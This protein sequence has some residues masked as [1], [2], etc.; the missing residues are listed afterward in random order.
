MSETGK[1]RDIFIL[2]VWRR[3]RKVL[4]LIVSDFLIFACLLL[5]LEAVHKFLQYSSMSAEHK[6]IIDKLHFWSVIFLLGFLAIFL[7]VE[8]VSF[9][10]R[11]L[12]NK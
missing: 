3:V 9:K 7:I 10:L 11:E 12:I 2:N 8:V 1:Q 5:M 6:E 4:E